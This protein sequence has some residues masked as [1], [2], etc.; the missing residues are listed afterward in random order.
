MRDW[1][2]LLVQMISI[3]EFMQ[4]GIPPTETVRREE[5]LVIH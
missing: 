4:I 5:A 3:D 2:S 1:T